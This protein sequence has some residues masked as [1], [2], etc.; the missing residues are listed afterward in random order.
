M[1]LELPEQHGLHRSPFENYTV[2]SLSVLKLF[3]LFQTILFLLNSSCLMYSLVFCFSFK[4]RILL[5]IFFANFKE[6]EPGDSCVFIK[7]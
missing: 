5:S 3:C 4:L 2:Q 7:T 1:V 6:L